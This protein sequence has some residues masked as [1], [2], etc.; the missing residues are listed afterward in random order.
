MVKTDENTKIQT[1]PTLPLTFDNTTIHIKEETNSK[2][3][4][5][6]MDLF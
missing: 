4:Q 2:L 6:A 3:I 5:D 1:Q